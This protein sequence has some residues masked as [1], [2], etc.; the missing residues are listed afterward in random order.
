MRALCCQKLFSSK[1]S[2]SKA[3]WAEEEVDK[4]GGKA[5]K[6]QRTKISRPRSAD[7]K[8]STNYVSGQPTLQRGGKTCLE[9]MVFHMTALSLPPSL[10]LSLS[11]SLSLSLYLHSC[12]SNCVQIATNGNGRATV[13]QKRA[14]DRDCLHVCYR[15]LHQLLHRF[16][17]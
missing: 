3:T 2:L 13:S 9:W 11:L 14:D 7:K 12:V 15:R 6:S 4:C 16:V 10:P 5:L 17:A 1:D 8:Y